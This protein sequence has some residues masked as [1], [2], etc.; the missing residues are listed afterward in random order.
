MQAKFFGTAIGAL[1]YGAGMY[2]AGV[3]YEQQKR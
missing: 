2:Y 1:L 3:V